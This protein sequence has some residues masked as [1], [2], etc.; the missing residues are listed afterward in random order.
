MRQM[1]KE[2]GILLVIVVVHQGKSKHLPKLHTQ[3]FAQMLLITLKRLRSIQVMT[4]SQHE[5]YKDPETE[6]AKWNSAIIHFVIYTCVFPAV[7]CLNVFSD[8]DQKED[9][10]VSSKLKEKL[11]SEFAALRQKKNPD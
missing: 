4:A 10:F 9:L 1:S 5:Q 8:N 11:I 3:A 7:T 2:I 6:A